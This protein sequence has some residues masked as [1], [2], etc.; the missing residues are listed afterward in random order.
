A[1]S[2]MLVVLAFAATA[3]ELLAVLSA[4]FP[5][6]AVLSA[7][8]DVAIDGYYLE[9]LD[10]RD[11]SRFVGFRAAAYRVA[12]LVVRGPLVVLV[13][14]VGWGVGLFAA[15][16]IF[17]ALTAFH[18]ACLPRAEAPGRRIGELLRRMLSRRI[19]LVA[20]ALAL[21]VVAEP[22]L[23]VIAPLWRAFT[24]TSVVRSLGVAGTI[25]V[26]L[27]LVLALTPIALPFVW[28]RIE[29]SDSHYARAF[30]TFR[31]QPRIGRALA[32]VMLFRT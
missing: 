12:A 7:T 24:E 4:I 20:G 27:L 21:A 29:R 9:A 25:G 18:L 1:L 14:L 30:V 6:M 15:A 23:R 13:G 31:D 10:E 17:A 8:H 11:Q 22:R 28:R 5:F 2:A 3:T 19:L 16:A 32:F 26:A